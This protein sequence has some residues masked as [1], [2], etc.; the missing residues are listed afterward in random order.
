MKRL[1]SRTVL[2]PMWKEILKNHLKNKYKE[3]IGT[4]QMF[5]NSVWPKKIST[6]SGMNN[7]TL[8]FTM[9]VSSQMIQ[10]YHKKLTSTA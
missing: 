8:Q 1:F 7:S 10:K 9:I 4:Q 5:V 6:S 2:E 3:S